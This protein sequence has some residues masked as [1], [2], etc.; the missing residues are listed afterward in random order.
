MSDED[1]ILQVLLSEAEDGDIDA[2]LSVAKEFESRANWLERTNWLERAAQCGSPEAMYQLAMFYKDNAF[3]Q[4][5]NQKVVEWLTE[6]TEGSEGNP[7]ANALF[8]FGMIYKNGLCGVAID[9]DMALY[10]LKK[11]LAAGNIDA[12]AQLDLLAPR[13]SS[14]PK[15]RSTA[16]AAPATAAAPASA[17]VAASSP[18]VDQVA[19]SVLAEQL[20]NAQKLLRAANAELA[21][22][23]SA[24]LVTG[25]R[26]QVSKFQDEANVL[27]AKL[28]TANK[29]LAA[30]QRDLVQLQNR[31]VKA[32]SDSGVVKESDQNNSDD[33][34]EDKDD[35]VD[36][37][38][39]DLNKVDLKNDRT[40]VMSVPTILASDIA[41]SDDRLSIRD[42][43]SV[44][45]AK[46]LHHE[47]AL[48]RRHNSESRAVTAFRRTAERWFKWRHPCLVTLYAIVPPPSTGSGVAKGSGAARGSPI[49]KKKGASEWFGFVSELCASS[50]SRWMQDH[51][52]GAPLE[53]AQSIARDVA[54]G[55]AF[56]HG[57]SPP[58]AHR[59]VKSDNVLLDDSGRAKLCDF[60]DA[61]EST[62]NAAL[63]AK[64]TM[65]FKGTQV[66]QS[67]EMRNEA[68]AA[69]RTCAVDTYSFGLVVLHLLSGHSPEA[70]DYMHSPPEK[71]I[72]QLRTTVAAE[73]R[74]EALFR[75]ADM[76]LHA[77][78][79]NRPT[80]NAIAQE[81]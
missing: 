43:H 77:E 40:I 78:P 67:P 37:N 59:D 70:D 69:M 22:A 53:R 66:W 80:M 18:S 75:I 68:H 38:K 32:T 62:E 81:L 5:D 28:D 57:L 23:P 46:W 56:L 73:R 76:C 30:A 36:D 42:E 15:E 7:H 9:R 19:H 60:D 44:F 51:G 71:I 72:D 34:D 11:A 16:A 29:L 64:V 20:A 33:K 25:L 4:R 10:F 39:V 17:A 65:S 52:D 61:I 1:A 12:R 35:K 14:P 55:L 58:V 45:K 27:R 21:N 13:K 8:E 41:V 54:S 63:D 6:A 31:T 79:K 50:L 74:N 2:M 48:K 26:D 47:V 3:G 24:K 49:G